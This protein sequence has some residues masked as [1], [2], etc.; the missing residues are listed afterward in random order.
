MT[1]ET[2]I[3]AL[4]SFARQ[5]PGLEFGNYGDVSAYRSEMR[6][7]TKD[8]HDARILL[9][10]LN[11][12]SI[13]AETLKRA[14]SAYSGRLSIVETDK[15]VKLDYCTGQYW[16]TEYRRAVCAV[17][18]SALWDHYR[19]GFAAS[20]KAGESPGDAIRRCFRFEFGRSIARRWFS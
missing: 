4:Y 5:R 1:R 9:G 13:D 15:G 18:A 3:D 7:I 14:F 8:L 11:R 10:A 2:I 20:A 12:S 19:D 6:S 17:A 16:P